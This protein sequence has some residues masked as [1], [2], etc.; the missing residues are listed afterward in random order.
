MYVIQDTGSQPQKLCLPSHP[1]F[2]LVHFGTRQSPAPASQVPSPTLFQPQVAQHVQGS[3]LNSKRRSDFPT[4][5]TKAL[6]SPSVLL[7]LT[8]L[9]PSPRRFR[10]CIS[11]D[12]HILL[13]ISTGVIPTDHSIFSPSTLRRPCTL[14]GNFNT[15]LVHLRPVSLSTKRLALP[16]SFP[17]H[18]H[19]AR[20]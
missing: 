1:F 4:F 16:T 11:E 20:S 8:N 15:H 6:R 9:D 5:C 19:V 14:C 17:I 3:T 12:A 10:P 18:E 13:L 7:S 2:A